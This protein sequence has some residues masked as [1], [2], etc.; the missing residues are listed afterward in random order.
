MSKGSMKILRKLPDAP[1]PT[2]P[3]RINTLST[4]KYMN[5][6]IGNTPAPLDKSG[7]NR[8]HNDGDHEKKIGEEGRVSAIEKARQRAVPVIELYKNGATNAE[9]SAATGICERTVRGIIG[10]YI[11][12]G[13]IKVTPSSEDKELA[14]LY[15]SGKSYDEMADEM[16][17]TGGALSSKLHKIRKMGLIGKREK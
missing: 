14:E 13:K 2:R 12:S 17:L 11:K 7:L 4:D 9:I 3:V 8:D 1:E 5:S 10:R 6:L 15:N 16:N